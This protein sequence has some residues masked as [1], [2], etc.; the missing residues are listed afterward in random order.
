MARQEGFITTWFDRAAKLKKTDAAAKEAMELRRASF[1]GVIDASRTDEPREPCEPLETNDDDAP[2]QWFQTLMQSPAMM[3]YF[4]AAPEERAATAP[5]LC[6]GVED[7]FEDPLTYNFPHNLK[8]VVPEMP[9]YFDP[10]TNRVRSDQCTFIV[11]N[12]TAS[13]QACIECPNNGDYLEYAEIRSKDRNLAK[14]SI[15]K[16]YL[17]PR[18]KDEAQQHYYARAER[19]RLAVLGRDRRLITSMRKLD[20]YKRLM[21]LIAT[22]KIARVREF[23]AVQL[24][25]G[26]SARAM[27]DLY[28]KACAGLYSPKSY[29]AEQIAET[30]L[31]WRLGGHALL[32]AQN[33]SN[34][35]GG[36][37]LSTAKRRG[38]L[39]P[40]HACVED[41]SLGAGESFNRVRLN[42]EPFLAKEVVGP[43][44]LYHLKMDDVKGDKRFRVSEKDGICRGVCYHAKDHVKLK[45]EKWSDIEAIRDALDVGDIHYG[46]ELTVFAIAANREVDYA[47]H[48][49]ALSAGCLKDDPMERTSQLL[50]HVIK[51][52]VMDS[53][54]QEARGILSTIQPDG[55]GQFVKICQGIFFKKR[56]TDSH[57][58]F[59]HLSGLALY[60]LWTGEGIFERVAARVRRLPRRPRPTITARE[61]RGA[62]TSNTNVSIM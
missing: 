37:S 61:R 31:A 4:A 52:F 6:R 26:S 39:D 44:C 49:V 45:I 40:F 23:L 24:R 38:K 60:P 48:V 7:N 41:V 25:R 33:N 19:L 5:S 55:A 56:M 1:L 12:G 22:N 46:T 28:K 27:C 3:T 34:S 51:T 58:L 20:D 50:E 47:P 15:K 21:Q 17:T 14:G 35:L 36:A 2:P 13:C 9:F 8:A 53:R 11:P 54:G 43:K 32:Y 57:P 42:Y 62:W 10:R 29:D 18:Q 59:R 16:A 30:V